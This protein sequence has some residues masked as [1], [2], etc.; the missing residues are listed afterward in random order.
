[1]RD[2]ELYAAILGVQL[3][4]QVTSVAL[5]PKAEEVRVLI[6]AVAGTRFRNDLTKGKPPL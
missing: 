5:D 3:P 4:W 2:H 6:E 1:M